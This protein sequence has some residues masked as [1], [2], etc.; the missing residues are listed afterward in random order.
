MFFSINLSL[1]FAYYLSQWWYK[2]TM[3]NL[4]SRFSGIVACWWQKICRQKKNHPP[5]T[6]I[7]PKTT[8]RYI[9]LPSYVFCFC[10]PLHMCAVFS[11]LSTIK[12]NLR[13]FHPQKTPDNSPS[14]HRYEGDHRHLFPN[15]VKP[16]DTEP[17][18]LLVY[19]WCQGVNNLTDVWVTWTLI[20]LGGG[21][22]HYVI[23]TPD[24]LGNDRIWLILFKGVETTTYSFDWFWLIWGNEKR[25]FK[26]K[27]LSFVVFE[28]TSLNPPFLFH[29]LLLW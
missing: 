21:F 3:L 20:F 23:F 17:A 5:F 6:R 11:T 15:W 27:G 10:F 4:Y 25:E 12:P 7:L 24:L 1:K 9:V 8:S 13:K 14:A 28:I 19:K 18:P 26:K 2:S 29:S 22:K 16:A